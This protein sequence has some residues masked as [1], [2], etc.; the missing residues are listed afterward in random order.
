LKNIVFFFPCKEVSGVAIQFLEIAHY[1][2][3][4]TSQYNIFLVDYIDGYMSINSDNLE[5]IILEKEKVTVI[6]EDSYF[7]TQA[8]PPFYLSDRLII[9]EETIMFFWALHPLNLSIFGKKD[10]SYNFIQRVGKTILSFLFFEKI[11]KLSKFLT[12]SKKLNGIVFM[13]SEVRQINSK[14]LNIPATGNLL[15]VPVS[16][17]AIPYRNGN[18]KPNPNDLHFAWLGRIS[19]MKTE[20]LI[21]TLNRVKNL[22]NSSKKNITFHLIGDGSD[23]SI[24]EEHLKTLEGNF[25]KYQIVGALHGKDKYE[26]LF[27]RVDLLFAMGISGLEGC[28][29]GI[30]TLMCDISYKPVVGYYPYKF[31]FE[32]KDFVMGS[33]IRDSNFSDKGVDPLQKVIDNLLLNYEEVSFLSYS[34]AKNHHSIEK[35][36]DKFLYHLE[37]SSLTKSIIN[38]NKLNKYDLITKIFHGLKYGEW[39]GKAWHE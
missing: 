32:T 26:Y 30:P 35:V 10:I 17:N 23:K 7:I 9:P 22:S 4:H 25:F 27:N 20:I 31:Y 33:I 8:I 24:V 19:D 14:T 36:T 3:T 37:Y 39:K 5:K 21:H 13:D 28:A 11:N 29:V 2:K 15:P 34:Y 38:S 12:I 6:P 18:Y 1:L 16:L